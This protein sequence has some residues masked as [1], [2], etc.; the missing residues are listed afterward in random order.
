M[1]A[2]DNGSLFSCTVSSQDISR[3]K[4]T[5][6]C[7]GLVCRNT[8]FQFDKRNGDLVEIEPQQPDS[9]DG[10]AVLALCQDAQNYAAKK[11]KLPPCCYR[12]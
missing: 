2:H 6:P 5:W 9:A 8:W 1:K 11:L 12:N 4:E 3:F 7:S 10:S